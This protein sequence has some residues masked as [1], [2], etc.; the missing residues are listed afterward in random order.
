MGRLNIGAGGASGRVP[1]APWGCWSLQAHRCHGHRAGVVQPL[2]M[3]KAVLTDVLQCSPWG[4]FGIPMGGSGSLR[5]IL[6]KHPPFAFHCHLDGGGDITPAVLAC[7]LF[8]SERR[9]IPHPPPQ[10]CQ[11]SL[12]LC[13]NPP[14]L[15]TALPISAPLLLTVVVA[16]EGLVLGGVGVEVAELPQVPDAV[17]KGADGQVLGREGLDVLYLAGA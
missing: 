1:A 14:E 7:L 8:C 9:S 2:G 12:P 13:S 4:G 5:G 11:P 17:A 16:P 10:P 15:P 6:H 3:G